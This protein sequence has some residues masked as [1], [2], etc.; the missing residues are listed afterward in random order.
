MIAGNTPTVVT[1][2]SGVS[3]AIQ[4]RSHQIL[5]DQTRKGGG[6]DSG[7]TPLELLG[8]S[9]GS[10]VAYYVHQFLHVRGLPADSVRVVVAQTRTTDPI[11]ID[12]FAVEIQLP[13][14]VPARYMPMLERVIDSC[15][16]H[17]TLS[18]SARIGVS[19]IAPSEVLA[20]V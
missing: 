17:N 9:L 3:F 10:C 18:H 2:L 11:R 4:I 7:P 6:A 20:S 16:A 14:G 12:S 5:V 13:P 1:H 8:A 19:F 15:P